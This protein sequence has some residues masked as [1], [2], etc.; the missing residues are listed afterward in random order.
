MVARN[1]QEFKSRF[2]ACGAA[3]AGSA[4]PSGVDQKAASA[5]HFTQEDWIASAQQRLAMTG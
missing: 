2:C 5:V 3:K 4:A 1:R